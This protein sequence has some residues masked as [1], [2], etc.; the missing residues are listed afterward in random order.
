MIWFAAA[1]ELPVLALLIYGKNEQ[2]TPTPDQRKAMLA[3]VEGMKR[4]ATR[5]SA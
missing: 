5:D 4:L 1:A 2:A 3:V